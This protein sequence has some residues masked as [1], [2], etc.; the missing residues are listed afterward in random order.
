[1]AH[2]TRTS[3]I[4]EKAQKR[5]LAL[6]SI[7]TYLD[8]GNGLTVREFTNQIEDT[9]SAIDRYNL[10]IKG[11]TQLHSEMIDSEKN[12]ADQHERML[13]GV[14]AKYGRSSTEYEMAGGTKRSGKRKP[15]AT[16]ATNPELPTVKLPSSSAKSTAPS[17]AL[18][19]MMN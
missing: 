10:A 19:A 6:K 2:R 8:L 5:S 12:L 7:D 14:C 13:S 17:P 15:K 11:L 3:L 18:T 16:T 9:Q 1:M 4:L